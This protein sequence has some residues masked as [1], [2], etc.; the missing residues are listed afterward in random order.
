MSAFIELFG[1][2]TFQQVI[3]ALIVAGLVERALD[4]F[5]FAKPKKE[6]AE[7]PAT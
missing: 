6:E 7:T 5:F 4:L 3:L 2:I 1:P